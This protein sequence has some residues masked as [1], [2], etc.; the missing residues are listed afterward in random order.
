VERATATGK[1]LGFFSAE[2]P[3]GLVIHGLKLMAGSRGDFWIAS[4]SVMKTAASGEPSVDAAGKPV[5]NNF[6]EFRSRDV[7]ANFENLLLNALRAAYPRLFEPAPR[8]TSTDR[9]PPARRRRP[10]QCQDPGQHRA[11]DGGKS[12]NIDD[13]WADPPR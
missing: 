12:D 7:R 8:D 11:D 10:R 13:L 2:L 1:M 6:I 5:W 4:P 9:A 3:S